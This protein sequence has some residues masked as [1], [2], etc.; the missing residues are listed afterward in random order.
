MV[1]LFVATGQMTPVCPTH[2]PRT[3]STRINPMH[4]PLVQGLYINESDH[5][6]VT[7]KENPFAPGTFIT[8]QVR[9]TG[10]ARAGCRQQR[11]V[12]SLHSVLNRAPTRRRGCRAGP[13]TGQPRLPACLLPAPPTH[14]PTLLLN[15]APSSRQVRLY[16]V[17]LCD[18]PEE[19]LRYVQAAQVRDGPPRDSG[20]L[21]MP[22]E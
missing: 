4:L 15:I 5:M 21:G 10:A 7:P 19:K 17:R 2:P 3:T 8:R 1:Q 18:S 12:A 6:F 16:L 11:G 9:P 13:A 22:A 20:G 14:P